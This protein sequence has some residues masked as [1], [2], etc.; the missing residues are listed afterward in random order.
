VEVAG[1]QRGSRE[2]ALLRVTSPGQ[3]RQGFP[4]AAG[5]SRALLGGGALRFEGVRVEDAVVLRHR[6]APGH[7]IALASALVLLLGL[8]LMG[9]RWLKPPAEVAG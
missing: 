8:G 5:G 6:R 2:V 1:V 3:P 9:R 7:P 4:L